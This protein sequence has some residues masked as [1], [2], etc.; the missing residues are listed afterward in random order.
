MLMPTFKPIGEEK[1]TVE[2]RCYLLELARK[3]LENGVM[4]EPLPTIDH[5]QLSEKLRTFGASFVTLTRR[6]MLRGCVGALEPY[7]GLAEDV[8]E[9]AV[10][11]ALE[12]YRFPPVRPE[13]LREICIEISYLTTPKVLE[14]E[15][16]EDLLRKLRPGV[17]GVV[18]RYGYQRATFLPQVWE[19][20]PEPAEFLAQ[21]CLK[22]GAK[23]D[24]WKQKKLD[25]L[26]YQVEEFQE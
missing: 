1:L 12:D 4:G 26:T 6:G 9:H 17:D 14:Y 13:E 11:A 2:E 3:S 5:Q 15:D 7:Q 18:I 25:V 10:A 21:L 23:A 24:L 19:K 8:R 22:M 16:T 20:I